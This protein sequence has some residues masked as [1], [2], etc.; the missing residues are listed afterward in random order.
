MARGAR[1]QSLL[2]HPV[3]VAER[4]ALPNTIQVHTLITTD[5][6]HGTIWLIMYNRYGGV[7]QFHHTPDQGYTGTDYIEW[8]TTEYDTEEKYEDQTTITISVNE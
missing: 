7:E 4:I 8:K 3:F 6:E 1:R 2:D 5:P